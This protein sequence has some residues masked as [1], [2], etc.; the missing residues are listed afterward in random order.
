MK[1]IHSKIKPEPTEFALRVYDLLRQVPRGRV[2]SYGEMARA[3]GNVSP[4]AVG[5]ALRRNPY[6]P[7]VPCHRVIATNGRIGGFQG[8]RSGLA[9]Q[10]KVKLL[11]S[12]GVVFEKG[13]VKDSA[14]VRLPCENQA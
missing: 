1:T 8:R 13:R 10:R 7:E 3:L 14:F 4:R 9:L 6:A 11:A 2:V 12:E 5:Q